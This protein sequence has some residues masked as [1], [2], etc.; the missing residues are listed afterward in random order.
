MKCWAWNMMFLE[1]F[2]LNIVMTISI[3]FSIILFS[4]EF[5]IHFSMFNFLHSRL[6]AHCLALY[7]ISISACVLLYFVRMPFLLVKFHLHL[8]ICSYLE[9]LQDN[10]NFIFI[11]FFWMQEYK[12]IA[13]LRLIH[14][15]RSPTNLSHF[16]ILVR[17]I[18]W[19][20]E[21]PFTE[22]VKNFFMNYHASSYLSH[23]MIYRTGKV[24]KLMVIILIS[25]Y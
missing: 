17:A 5:L 11:F 14:I 23:Q 2:P 13:N 8:S 10:L 7:I 21:E 22:S 19:S 18:P 12:R 6:W 25:T 4:V 15:S 1:V 3:F 9:N 16:A 24:E 20:L